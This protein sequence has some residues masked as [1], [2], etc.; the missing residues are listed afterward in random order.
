MTPKR[1]AVTWV[2][3]RGDVIWIDHNPQAGREMKDH[4]PFVVLSTAGFN[5]SVGLVV[6][7]VM[8]SAPYNWG[9]SLAVDLGPIPERPDAHSFVLCHHIQSFD[10]KARSAR[11]HPLARLDGDKQV[12]VLEIVGQILGFLP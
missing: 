9:S 3:D 1:S 6:G 8:T 7:C 2:P 4:H 12:Q 10:W 11:P 5:R